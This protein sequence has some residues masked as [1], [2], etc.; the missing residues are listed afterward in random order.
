MNG[1]GQIAYD[2]VSFSIDPVMGVSLA[3]DLRID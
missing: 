3:D 2:I 1:A